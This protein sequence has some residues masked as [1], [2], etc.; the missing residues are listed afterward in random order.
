MGGGVRGCGIS[1][2]SLFF[3]FAFG[4]CELSAFSNFL[5]GFQFPASRWPRSQG[6][7]ATVSHCAPWPLSVAGR[8]GGAG[9]PFAHDTW[10]P[11]QMY[12][13]WLCFVL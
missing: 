10:T 3:G 13:K 7:V 9:R 2:G 11:F 4:H 5:T 1:Y 12:L 8:V 6:T